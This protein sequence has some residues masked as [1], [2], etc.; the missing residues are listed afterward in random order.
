MQYGAGVQSDEGGTLDVVLTAD[1]A[2]E[3]VTP[4]G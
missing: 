4:G 1:G 2:V 3:S